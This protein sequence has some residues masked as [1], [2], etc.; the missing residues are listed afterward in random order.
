ML[1][2]IFSK[3]F[4]T[5]ALVGRTNRLTEPLQIGFINDLLH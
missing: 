5:I 2:H 3:I 4:N 1:I